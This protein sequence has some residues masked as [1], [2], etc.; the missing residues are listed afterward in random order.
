MFPARY[1][2]PVPP[3]PTPADRHR[4]LRAGQRFARHV[5]EWVSRWPWFATVRTLWRRFREDRL[6]ITA[7]SLTFTSLLAL[8]PMVA[9]VAAVLTAFPV[10]DGFQATVQQK[11]LEHLVPETIARPLLRALRQFA[12]NARG[13]GSAGLVL[14]IASALALML[15]IDRTLNAIW[16]VRR[17]R[18]LAQRVLVYWAALTLGPLA[19]AAS[20]SL[21]SYAVSASRG[22]V[23]ALP[24]GVS[25][26]LGLLQ[27]AALAAAVAGLFRYVPNVV[28]AWRHAWAG[29]LFVALAFE[30]A[31]RALAWYVESLSNLTIVYGALATLPIL[32][33]WVFLCWVIL[34][35]GAVVAAYAPSLQLR[36]A[37]RPRVPGWRFE[38]ALEVLRELQPVPGDATARGATLPALAE[39]LRTD[40]LRIEPVIEL[41]VDLDWIA[42]LD[43]A[44]HG[45]YVL[46]CDPKTTPIAPLLQRALLA[47]A[48][49][50]GGLFERVGLT[51]TT[52]AEALAGGAARGA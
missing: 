11:L 23:A 25:V 26:A 22:M 39:S 42:R 8:V 24:G 19:L 38:L 48:P 49:V 15:T 52:L 4:A 45:R 28:V 44:G 7:G 12:G 5:F 36:L 33:L 41:L 17:K 37:D 9:V 21:T 20:L 27:F 43:E 14:L 2:P 47:P 13:M 29:A 51:T 1:P 32:L 10:F 35:L 34:L 31:K 30:G 50:S 3:P 16:R 6:G 18:P 46:L 40:P